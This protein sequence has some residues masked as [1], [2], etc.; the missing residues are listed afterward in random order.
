[1]RRHVEKERA[2]RIANPEHPNETEDCP[3][4]VMLRHYAEIEELAGELG[5]EA[6]AAP[7]AYDAAYYERAMRALLHRR[8]V[9]VLHM[10]QI[11][12]VASRSVYDYDIAKHDVVPSE[13]EAR[14]ALAAAE[15]KGDADERCE[16][17]WK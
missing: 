11:L 3:P 5:I 9:L 8:R 17:W 4:A 16:R 6:P 14:A 10:D 7:G 15:A 1:M 2:R 13:A 12:D